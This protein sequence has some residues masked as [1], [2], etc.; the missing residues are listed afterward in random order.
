[1]HDLTTGVTT[2]VSVGADG[3]A[4]NGTSAAPAFS[5]DGNAITFWTDATNVLPVGAGGLVERDLVAGSTT[6]LVQGGGGAPVYA[7]SGAVV[8]FSAYSPPV[9]T[10]DEYPPAGV[11]SVN[12]A[13]GA[14]ELLSPLVVSSITPGQPAFEVSPDS[15]DVLFTSSRA[16]AGIPDGNGPPG[17]HDGDDVFV[18]DL[19]AGTTT[20]ISVNAA[21][22]GT[23]DGPSFGPAWNADGS[24]VAFASRASDLDPAAGQVA[25]SLEEQVYVRDLVAGTTRLASVRATG[26]QRADGFASG[27]RFLADGRV[28]FLSNSTDLDDLD[29]DQSSVDVFVARQSGADLAVTLTDAPDPVAGGGTLTYTVT[30]ENRG[31]DEADD[32]TVALL[33]PADVVYTNSSPSA[34]SCAPAPTNPA[35]VTCVIGSLAVGAS[36]A[37]EISGS[38]AAPVGAELSA[39]AVATS[40]AVDPTGNAVQ[41]TTTVD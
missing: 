12:R 32:L 9:G 10:P 41:A 21:R 18:V 37:V 11:F 24:Q 31:P 34:A 6:L 14:V 28:A 25:G 38:V 26:A 2:L 36:L 39:V 30:V 3:S 40:P 33:L 29:D 15:T 7:L 23:G 22:T 17:S 4:G 27:P 19:Q 13:S 8:L 20:P 35:V 1:M 5:P 16:D